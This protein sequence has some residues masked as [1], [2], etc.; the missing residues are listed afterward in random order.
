MRLLSLAL[1][2]GLATAL[3][4]YQDAI[5]HPAPPPVLVSGSLG[6]Q[7][8]QPASQDHAGQDSD[9]CQACAGN[10]VGVQLD[11]GVPSVLLASGGGV[12]SG[13]GEG[14]L[15][16]IGGVP[17]VGSGIDISAQVGDG[18]VVTHQSSSSSR[19]FSQSSHSSQTSYFV[20]SGGDDIIE[21]VV[22][23]A[24]D[25][26]LECVPAA[27]L[28]ESAKIIVEESG[29]KGEKEAVAAVGDGGAAAS[30]SARDAAASSV[31]VGVA[32]DGAAS[33]SS[34]GGEEHGAAASSA[35]GGDGAASSSAAGGGAASSAAA[36]GLELGG[37]S[38]SA[39][40]GG[41]ASSAAAGGE[42]HGA[43][44]S[45]A[46]G[47]GAA[48]SAAAGGGAAS[49]AAAGGEEHGAASSSAAGGAASSAAA[50][51]L[52]HGA[53]SSSA[54]AGGAASSAAA[55]GEEHGAASSSA[56]AG[57]AASSAAA[58]GEEHGA[59]SS[60]AAGGGAASSAA[61][62]GLEL[63]GSSSSA[64]AGGAASS[65]AA[66]GEE[67]GA[68][69]S[70]A[71]GG[72]AASSAAAGGA[73]SSAAAGGREHGAASSS[74]AGGGAASSA[75]AGGLELGAASSSAAGGGAASSSAA[76]GGAASSAAAGG[77]GQ[78][79][80]SSS[81]AAGG[82]ASAASSGGAS[83]STSVSGG[84]ISVIEDTHEEI[85]QDCI[86]VP[87]YLCKGGDIITDGAGLIDIRFGPAEGEGPKS[88]S[89]CKSFLDVCCKVP[90][91]FKESESQF[92]EFPWMAIILEEQRQGGKRLEK[93][94]CGGSLIADDVILT[95]GHCVNDKRA[96]SIVVRLGDWDTKRETEIFPHEQFHVKHIEVHEDLN[97]R[98][99]F[100][101]VA[102][103]FLDGKVT[104]QPH[105]DTICLPEPDEDFDYAHCVATGFGRDKFEG[106]TY[107]NI[108][109]QV[110]LN[111]VPHDA[112][113]TKL[114]T[115]RLGRWFKLHDSFTCAGG[116]PGVDTC[117]GDGGSPLVCPSKTDPNKYVQA[118]IVAWGIGCGEGGVPGV[119]A[120][121][122]KLLTWVQEKL[123][124]FPASGLPDRLQQQHQPVPVQVVQTPVQVSLPP[125]PPPHTLVSSGY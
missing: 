59:A 10:G 111:I 13:D 63:G 85:I 73:A 124:A 125:P 2:V 112:C 15:A 29:E 7:L 105:I 1:C 83:S 78:G 40:A 8:S 34:V 113:Q 103:L 88:N 64:A 44:S 104:L 108:M 69:S 45:S 66:G 35:A 86:C 90:T 18:R 21:I 122:P 36:G 5:S 53:A 72:G 74:A 41:A 30:S 77:A 62:G 23:Q 70:S 115:T 31:T 39:A 118:G 71:A 56:A 106:G 43:A 20:S 26:G 84:E 110:D 58:G 47:G 14:G 68:A 119:Y 32:G 25:Y 4:T 19:Q 101:D 98:T 48:S 11:V 27:D 100:N 76:G 120:S 24:A 89:Q 80:S 57:G 50:G 99:L 55:G 22:A 91:G 3:P 117:K 61:A 87:Y 94:L 102:L 121:V 114:R 79:A 75:A 49:S 33:S 116:E 9:G 67:H 95:A 96:G 46:A 52:E 17:S 28:T 37:S 51:G 60:S 38:S 16:S 109:K 97:P 81:A 6:G 54:A 92:G 82:A 65:A 107:Q 123:A 12:L 42:E 93:Y